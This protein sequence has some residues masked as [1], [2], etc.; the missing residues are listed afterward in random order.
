MQ[1]K[2]T[3]KTKLYIVVASVTLI[4][5]SVY[6]FIYRNQL[7]KIKT[8]NSQ[9]SVLE[10]EFVKVKKDEAFLPKLEEQILA[11]NLKIESFNLNIPAEPA[12]PELVESL[13]QLATRI[14]IKDYISLTPKESRTVEKY[15]IVPMELNFKC[16]YPKLIQYLKELETL[17]RL[18]R[19]DSIKLRADDADLTQLN[20]LL[21]L[22]A[23]SI[24]VAKPK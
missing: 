3:V 12:V 2:L 22:T 7:Q 21:E 4:V 8:L 17:N 13:G 20:V 16:S 15:I 6:F 18:V 11:D 24:T 23:F 14:G 19:V 5:F 10:T 9:L 1:F